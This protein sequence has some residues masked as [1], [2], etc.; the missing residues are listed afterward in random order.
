MVN[1]AQAWFDNVQSQVGLLTLPFFDT[2]AAII[3][4]K[5]TGRSIY[6][7]DR[8]HLHHCL[9]RS[10]LSSRRALAL[11][12]AFC[13]ITVFG[14]LASLALKNELLALLSGFVVVALLVV[15]RLFGHAEF[16]LVKTR[17]GAFLG[18]LLRWRS[19]AP[20][21]T[22][23]RLQGS[24][25]WTELW[26]NLLHWAQRLNLKMVRLNVNAP[27]LHENYHARRDRGLDPDEQGNHWRAEIPLVAQGHPLG[28][29]EISGSRD[30]EPVWMKIQTLSQM[31]Q[32]FET[33][34]ELLVNGV[35]AG[36]A[37]PG[38]RYTL[39][40]DQVHAS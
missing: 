7:T 34:A 29:L 36:A 16:V 5:L 14:T 10:G 18:S 40:E 30:D 8:G 39:T 13:M 33:T 20:Q 4:R 9:L 22:M 28:R 37:K 31:V 35:W 17:L 38:T 15:T 21:H 19:P 6:T 26:A 3:R 27:A 23:V 32:T 25:D 11:V 2:L 1:G 24:A 12:S